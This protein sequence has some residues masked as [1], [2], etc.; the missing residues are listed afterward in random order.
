VSDGITEHDGYHE[1][2]IGLG[3]ILGLVAGATMQWVHPGALWP[4]V[5]G[6][7]AIEDVA[8]AV[9]AVVEIRIAGG[10]RARRNRQPAVSDGFL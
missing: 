10:I 1:A 5:L 3:R 7:S 9:E 2:L 6:G 4:A 8:A